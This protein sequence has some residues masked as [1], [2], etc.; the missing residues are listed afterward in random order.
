MGD[1]KKVRVV[2]LNPP[3]LNVVSAATPKYVDENRGCNPP[4]GLLYIQ[5]AVENSRHEAIFLD[6]NLEGW[7]HEESARQALSHNPDIIGLQAMTFTLPDAYLVVKKI[8]SI[9]PDIKTIIGGPHPTIYPRETAELEGVDFAFSGEGEKGFISF[10]DAY[11]N[12]QERYTVPGIACKHDG[13]VL[14]TQ[15]N[16]LISNLDSIHYPA[17]KSSKYALYTSVLA[18]RNPISIMITSRGC[19]YKCV[20]C[21]RMGRKYRY[22]SAQYV[23]GEIEDILQLGIKEIFIHDDTFTINRERILEICREIIER[24]FDIIWEARTRVDCIDEKMI[25]MMRRAGCHRLSFGVE[26]GSEKVIKSIKKGITIEQ[27]ERAFEWC[28]KEGIITL[29]DFMIGNIDEEMPDIQK[30]VDLVRKI[31]PDYVQYSVCSPYPDTPLYK[32]GL[33]NRIIPRDVWLDFAK[34]P[35]QDFHSPLWTQNFTEEELNKITADAYKAFYMRPAFMLK[36][37]MRINS[38]SQLKPMLHV[39]VGMLRNR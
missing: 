7:N 22:H 16:G 31:N 12:T 32:I 10:L 34:D 28:R 6:A 13:N 24:K 23:L 35:L 21:N 8:K 39:A 17:R 2:L 27:V 18:K 25:S 29:A 5:A 9:N 36:Q 1:K 19:P 26:S 38:F 14:Y 20:F 11:H 30:S 15:S 33:E 3:L 4:M 37:L